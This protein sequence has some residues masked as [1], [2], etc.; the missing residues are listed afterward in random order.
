MPRFGTRTSSEYLGRQNGRAARPS[1]SNPQERR[2]MPEDIRV[3][4]LEL[5]FLCS[6]HDTGGGLD[7][8]EM[9]CPPDGRMP[10]PHYH[11]DWDETI[12][13]LSG[14]VTF[15]VDG[16]QVE[17]GPG[18]TIFIRRGVVHGFDNRSKA[19]ARCL[20]VLTP[21]VLG[22]EFFREMG[23]ELAANTPPDPA[24]MR[25]IMERHGLIPAARA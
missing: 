11:R 2:A 9:T 1:G 19:P 12:Y 25:T 10:V 15:T 16:K 22:P 7:M 17:I 5:R 4:S 23:A 8:L 3:G 13:G 6:K 24:K 14:V 18:D 21:G 20:C